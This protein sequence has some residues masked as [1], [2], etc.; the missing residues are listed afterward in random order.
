MT[1]DL[2]C[3]TQMSIGKTDQTSTD[4]VLH[5]TGKIG[6]TLLIQCAL[7]LWLSMT[8]LIAFS[9]MKSLNLS[10]FTKPIRW[11]FR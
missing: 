10:N 6:P 9:V 4:R 8:K 11:G 5:P 1:Q 2:L 3:V 7:S